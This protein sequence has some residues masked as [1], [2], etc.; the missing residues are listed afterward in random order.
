[1]IQIK[2]NG[3]PITGR[4]DGL[5]SFTATYSRDSD[6][7]RTQKTYTNELKFYDDGFN[8]IYPILVSS[9][10]GLNASINVEVW[11]DCC[12]TLIV[13]NFII[14]GNAVDYCSNDCFVT[15]RLT[16]QDPDE[17]IYECLE[18]NK[19]NDNRNGY[20][21][22]FGIFPQVAYCNEL[23]PNWLMRYLIIQGLILVLTF[24]V[25][26]PALQLTI[27]LIIAQIFAICATLKT[28]Q[29]II[30]SLSPGNPANFVPGICNTI[31]SD[32][33][34]IFK[35]IDNFIE[36]LIQNF[37]GCGRKQP[38]V[39][40]RQYIENACQICGINQFNSSIF[41]NPSS[42][43]WNA[44]YFNAPVKP[45]TRNPQSIIFDNLPSTTMFAWLTT[46]SR[47]FNSNWWIKNGQLYFER[48][49][50]YLQ[51]PPIYDAAA[52]ASTGDILDGVCFKYSS[53]LQYQAIN[54]NPTLDPLDD[55]GNEDRD[56]YRRFVNY[57][58][59]PNW[60]GTQEVGLSFAPA[61]FRNDGVEPDVLSE[62]G[63]IGLINWFLK[64]QLT[65]T[66]NYLLMSRGTAGVPK[67]LIWDGQ[68]TTTAIIK[69]YNGVQ[70]VP[71][72]VNSGQNDLFDNQWAINSPN[73]NPYRFWDAT[74]TV[75]MSCALAQTLNV[76]STVRLMTPY[77][78]IVN[79][80]INTITANFG[81]REITFEVEF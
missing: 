23:R 4:I 29:N 19:V 21:N 38:T 54:I 1:M 42:E 80:R 70:N 46:A 52:N 49:D 28:I 61:R 79:A 18:N 8:I 77:G 20:F 62:F 14:Q 63:R 68:S 34:Q 69:F 81:S 27:A 11:D 9:P 74:L 36:D 47:D 24:K 15:C 55:V 73:L 35:I 3:T 60:K 53:K 7:G 78:A 43:Y 33:L 65:G 51:S 48:R 45:S 56:R 37:I 2:L 41:N 58:S 32:P 57:G 22:N 44:L 71:A 31:L 16:R 6:T 76:N 39:L 50:Y 72:M 59:N 13:N 17:L 64:G 67:L 5:E 10:T 25:S 30:N 66:D 75:R 12:N 40:Y 26:F